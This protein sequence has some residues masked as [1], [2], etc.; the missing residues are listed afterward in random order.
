VESK[1]RK[2]LIEFV[3]QAIPYMQ[4]QV[5]ERIIFYIVKYRLEIEFSDPKIYPQI[6]IKNIN[7]R[8]RK[9]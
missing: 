9:K 3:Y 5:K 8:I 2:L 4:S 6:C 7:M 1:L